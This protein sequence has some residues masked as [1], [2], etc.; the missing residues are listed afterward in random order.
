MNKI[1]TSPALVLCLVCSLPVLSQTTAAHWLKV[2]DKSIV[3]ATG[4]PYILRGMG[5]GGW[6][7][8]ESYMFHLG[9]I[10]PQYRIRQ[11]ISELIGTEKTAAF[12]DSW[13]SGHTT[14][15]DIDSLAAWGFNSVRLPMHYGL[16]TL[17]VEEEPAP[18][19]NTWLN[20]GFEITDSLLSW[21]KGQQY[22]PDP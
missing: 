4:H 2:K 7:L 11:K 9:G 22:V 21:C 6:M 12:Y 13:L 17:P 3:D 5:L 10:G 20:K 19:Q 8:Q 18:G 16:Y 15:T 1:S 14:K